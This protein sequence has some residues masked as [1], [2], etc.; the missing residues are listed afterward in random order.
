MLLAALK[1]RSV[2]TISLWRRGS[3]IK[4]HPPQMKICLTPAKP[5]RRRFNVSLFFS[6]FC[7]ISWF[8]DSGGFRKSPVQI[9]WQAGQFVGAVDSARGK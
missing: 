9:I 4:H 1:E 7:R 8:S 2:A 5:A 6:G 3:I